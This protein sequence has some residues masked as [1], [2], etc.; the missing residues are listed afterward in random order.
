MP[1]INTKGLYTT[2]IPLTSMKE[3]EFECNLEEV[4]VIIAKKLI[5]GNPRSKCINVVKGKGNYSVEVSFDIIKTKSK[6]KPKPKKPSDDSNDDSDDD[7][8]EDTLE[9]KPVG[10]FG[11]LTSKPYP[12]VL[13]NSRI[14]YPIQDEFISKISSENRSVLVNMSKAFKSFYSPYYKIL[15][16]KD[17]SIIFDGSHI[18]FGIMCGIGNLDCEIDFE[19]PNKPFKGL[20]KFMGA[21]IA[22]FEILRTTL[23]EFIIRHKYYTTYAAFESNEL[24]AELGCSPM[25]CV[26]AKP[27]PFNRPLCSL[28]RLRETWL[29][30]MVDPSEN[31]SAKYHKKPLKCPKYFP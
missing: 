5:I 28:S 6:A 30:L 26:Q 2:I 1:N 23:P 25:R 19:L 17:G 3:Y 24:S 29:S 27:S 10:A 9:S 8:D 15:V 31:E 13:V 22:N 4:N 12:H 18:G 11:K 20:L 16:G 7:S 14:D 21:S